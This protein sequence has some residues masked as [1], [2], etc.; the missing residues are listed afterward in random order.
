[1]P[2]QL[3]VRTQALLYAL[4][5][6]APHEVLIRARAS[7]NSNDPVHSQLLESLFPC[8]QHIQFP[9]HPPGRQFEIFDVIQCSAKNVRFA[10][11]LLSLLG[12]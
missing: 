8:I 12:S 5:C 10:I 4:K 3:E 1:M 7:I 11:F 6:L 2:D 9:S